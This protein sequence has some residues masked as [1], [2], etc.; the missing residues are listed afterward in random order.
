MTAGRRKV[1]IEMQGYRP[2]E[3]EIELTAGQ[4]AEVRA[5]LAKGGPEL[6]GAPRITQALISD[7]ATRLQ[8]RPGRIYLYGMAV[9]GPGRSTLFSL[10]QY[11]S[12]TH[13][14]GQLAASVAYGTND[15]NT[16]T[17]QTDRHILGGASIGGSWLS[18]RAFYGSNA[19]AGAS[20]VSV[21]FT[22]EQNS[23]V[24]VLA[25]ASASSRS[26]SKACPAWRWTSFHG[27]PDAAASMVI[28]HAELAPGSY[29]VIERSSAAGRRRRPRP[30]VRSPRRLRLRP[31]LTAAPNQ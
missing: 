12:V 8:L 5:V 1:R 26:H 13:A 29:T 9:G 21:T 19:A 3:N 28:A 18:M 16:Y 22:V 7:G 20:D 23:F 6:D 15:I 4:T 24:V 11:A 2:Y 27:G 10:G 14:A 25:L 17:T 31:P 30:H